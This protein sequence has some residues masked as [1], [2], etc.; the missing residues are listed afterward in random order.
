MLTTNRARLQERRGIALILILG[1][2]GLLAFIGVT[3]ATISGQ[4]RVGARNY[5]QSVMRPQPAALMEYALSQL[6][7]DTDD[8][9]SAIRG[10]SMARDAYGNDAY[11]NGYLPQSA[12]FS[13]ATALPLDSTVTTPAG[14]SLAG[15][16]QCVTTMP[17]ST[18]GSLAFYGFDF[19]RWLVRFNGQL[20]RPVDGSRFERRALGQTYEIVY[21]DPTGALNSGAGKF[22]TFFL[23]PLSANPQD[24]MGERGTTYDTWFR[25]PDVIRNPSAQAVEV[26]GSLLIGESGQPY[27]SSGVPR[28]VTFTLDGRFLRAF[29]GPGMGPLAHYANMRYNAGMLLGTPTLADGSLYIAP[30]DPNVVGMDED[31]DACDLENWFLAIQS[32]DGKAIVPSFHRPG[33]LTQADWTSP[34]ASSRSKILRPRKSDGHDPVSF[35]NLTP[36]A[37]TGKIEYDVDNDA[38]GVTDSVWV[39]LGYPPVRDSRG[40]SYK[41]LFAFL[42]IG[43][44]GR[45]PLNTAGN[46]QMR[47][48]AGAPLSMHTSHLGYSPSEVDPSFGLL[49]TG[50]IQLDN[51][52]VPVNVTQLRNIL[53]GARPYVDASYS[54]QNFVNNDGDPYYLPNNVLDSTDVLD[55]SKYGRLPPR[56]VAGRW[57]EEDFIASLLDGN[58]YTASLTSFV[59]LVRAGVSVTG[60]GSPLTQIADG[61]DD[62]LT[63][64]DFWPVTSAPPLGGEF[65]GKSALADPSNL[66]AARNSPPA[67]GKQWG[68][69][70][71]ADYADA[72]G[73]S[74]VFSERARRFVTPIDIAGDGRV[75]ILGS[76]GTIGNDDF[77]RV[78]FHKYFRP[79]GF[80][81][82]TVQN[83]PV[84]T[85]ISGRTTSQGS[86]PSVYDVTNNPYHGFESHRN[87]RI[88]VKQ[89]DGSWAD[90][91]WKEALHYAATPT[92]TDP[93]GGAGPTT[94]G[95][96]Y[97]SDGATQAPTYGVS[98]NSA[99]IGNPGLNEAD[100]T[101]V[102][103]PN[104]SD[105]IFGFE[106]LE[107]LYRGHDQDGSSLYSRLSEL[108]PLSLR[109]ASDAVRRRR[110]YSIDVWETNAFAWANDN[111]GG[112][113][114][115]SGF[116][117]AKGWFDATDPTKPVDKNSRFQTPFTLNTNTNLPQIKTVVGIGA[118]ANASLLSLS[119]QPAA[120]RANYVNVESNSPF[121]SSAPSLVHRDRKINLNYPFPV[122]NDSKEATRRKWIFESY[123]FLKNALPP[124]SV[125]TPEELAM[126]SQFLVNIV[127][128]RDPDGTMTQFTNPDVFIRPGAVGTAPGLVPATDVTLNTTD[129]ARPIDQPLV[130]FGMEYNPIAINEVLAY[131]F[132]TLPGQKA[133]GTE[134]GVGRFFIEVINTLTDAHTTE[135]ANNASWL[136]LGGLSPGVGYAGGCWDL[137]FTDDDP[138]SRPDP[139]TGQLP[140]GAPGCYAPT[141]LSSLALS[142]TPVARSLPLSG[143]PAAIPTASLLTISNTIPAVVGNTSAEISPV[144]PTQTISDTF[145]PMIT[146]GASP[147]GPTT[148]QITAAQWQG[149]FPK[150]AGGNAATTTSFP[151]KRIPLPAAVKLSNYKWVCLRRPA[152][153]FAAVSVDNPMVVVDT[154]RFAYIEGTGPLD[155]SKKDKTTP[156]PIT[157]PNVDGAP[158]AGTYNR[159]YS[160]Q[161]FQPYRGGQLVAEANSLARVDPKDAASAFKPMDVTRY[162]YSEQLNQSTTTSAMRG[163]YL[164]SDMAYYSTALLF[165]SLGVNVDATQQDTRWNRFV[166]N[167]REF[168]SPAELML[169]PGCP[170]GLFTKLFAEFE[171]TAG[172]VKPIVFPTTAPVANTPPPAIPTTVALGFNTDESTSYPYLQD[173]LFYSS[174]SPTREGNAAGAGWDAVHGPSSG[175]WYKM[176]EFFEVPSTAIGATGP[177][178]QGVNFD[179]L[180]QDVR[181]GQVN[182]NLIIDEEVFLG[183]MGNAGDHTTGLPTVVPPKLQGI[184]IAANTAPRIVTQLANSGVPS[185][186]YPLENVGFSIGNLKNAFVDFLGLRHGATNIA[187]LGNFSLLYFGSLPVTSGGLTTEKAAETPFRS[188]TYPDINST[189]MR[190]AFPTA[191]QS[192]FN[193]AMFDHGVTKAD[194]GIKNKDLVYRQGTRPY[195]PP[196][197]PPRRLFSLPDTK[198]SSNATLAPSDTK[199]LGFKPGTLVSLKDNRANLTAVDPAA[200]LK[201]T[202]SLP[203]SAQHPY[204]R[205]EWLQKLMNLSTVRS[206]QYAVW[207]TVGFFEVTTVGDPAM[208]SIDPDAAYDVLGREVGTTTGKST[209]HRGFFVVDRLKLNGFDPRSPGQYR[210]AVLYRRVIQ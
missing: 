53:A 26:V 165:H 147:A 134:V 42:V 83:V 121:Q 18:S 166:F 19:T 164:N 38:D 113:G 190:P 68:T 148:A 140:P 65:M 129:T 16:I 123:Q 87:P 192:A 138:G 193:H 46:L 81:V 146:G 72:S 108:A 175:G 105:A 163:V 126:L 136:N 130:Q 3:F 128:F 153:P 186:S 107:W 45:I 156:T 101:D 82:A 63:T 150:D 30:G 174:A 118:T 57:G 157:V 49:N 88:P 23:V 209:R 95:L 47:S 41:P 197:I 14:L 210:D 62:N 8:V 131:S 31:Y 102:Y 195:L 167:D 194:P 21:D 80:P 137:I 188:L 79:P 29:N 151:Y 120:Q 198:A 98:L 99:Y 25:S 183:L 160:M 48:D 92:S 54:D 35:R 200:P 73:I 71:P 32:A 111:P 109:D 50:A 34:S 58:T 168:M 1:M 203:D 100:E 178:A 36:N 66:L 199:S 51:A 205:T 69:N 12:S 170:P 142:A 85:T 78:G 89:S 40:L 135:T 143:N 70:W 2:L 176:F 158:A 86:L 206:H 127:D 33:I 110:L 172:N 177:A 179:W 132:K 27:N 124:L 22:R 84:P 94:G 152:N 202:A 7:G 207:V 173:R 204:Y 144:T 180:R 169:V 191:N 59:N 139:F 162:G 187:A 145:N 61:R 104:P 74:S 5:A 9:R 114:T 103:N 28:G 44:N 15:T 184:P 90:A 159:I 4:A 185:A 208:A 20:D 93:T 125:D 10:H 56:A 91:S 64:L 122:S 55:A 76:P 189:I 106:D 141:P 52:G 117:G 37:A 13:A 161:R 24:R 75:E 60:S 154:M 67:L 17:A 97:S 155:G 171:P 39:D 149:I 119:Q 181:P 201:S 6:I 43:L 196:A 115:A 96:P 77:G 112:Y 11:N 133:G 116:Y 182:L